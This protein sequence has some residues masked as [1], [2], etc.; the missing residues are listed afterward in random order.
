MHRRA[1]LSVVQNSCGQEKAFPLLRHAMPMEKPSSIGGKTGVIAMH[2]SD[3]RV[4]SLKM[5][6]LAHKFMPTPGYCW[7]VAGRRYKNAK[8][9]TECWF[10]GHWEVRNREYE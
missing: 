10:D 2:L 6:R 8:K 3:L 4:C 1:V 9:R 5:A 7:P